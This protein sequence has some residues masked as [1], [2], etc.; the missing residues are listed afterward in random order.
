MNRFRLSY[1]FHIDR[2]IA[3]EDLVL[4]QISSQLYD[5]LIIDFSYLI[6]TFQML[7]IFFL[8]SRHDIE[9]YYHDKV[10]IIEIL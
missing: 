7:Y 1:S 9:T 8:C 3:N 10:K 4:F 5:Q 2:I 6:I